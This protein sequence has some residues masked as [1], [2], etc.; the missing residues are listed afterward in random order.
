MDS[1]IQRLNNRGELFLD[2][3]D[4][5]TQGKKR[6]GGLLPLRMFPSRAQMNQKKKK[7]T[8]STRGSP[9]DG[10]HIRY[11]LQGYLITRFEHGRIYIKGNS[12]RD[13]T[14]IQKAWRCILYMLLLLNVFYDCEK[15]KIN[16]P[17]N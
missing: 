14:I 6:R 3:E 8:L 13:S 1:A 2:F 7:A 15:R 9:C 17:W 4:A 5:R 16:E 10:I 12:F 11:L